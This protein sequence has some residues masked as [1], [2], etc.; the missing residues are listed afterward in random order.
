MELTV[1]HPLF[2]VM[3]VT[4]LKVLFHCQLKYILAYYMNIMSIKQVNVTNMIKEC[5]EVGQKYQ[6][7]TGVAF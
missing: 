7:C 3:V 2:F 6:W 1:H 4:R 5:L